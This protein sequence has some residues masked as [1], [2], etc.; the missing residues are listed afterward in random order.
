MSDSTI[1]LFDALLGRIGVNLKVEDLGDG[2]YA[3]STVPGAAGAVALSNGAASDT[4][5]TL[6]A[7]NTSRRGLLIFNDADKPLLLKYGAVASPTSF[8]VKIAAGGYWEMPQ[9]VYQGIIDGIWEAGPTG[10]A[11]V[12]ELT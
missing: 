9:P 8:T 1:P 7:A 11:R 4:S 3:V 12:T 6:K 5:S 10:A 2:S